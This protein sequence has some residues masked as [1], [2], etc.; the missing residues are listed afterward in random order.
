MGSILPKERQGR[1]LSEIKSSSRD[2]SSGLGDGQRGK[3]ATA[4]HCGLG[5]L[6]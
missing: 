1:G 2:K 5:L 6:R 4:G 3:C